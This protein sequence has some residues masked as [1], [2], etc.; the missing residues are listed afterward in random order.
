MLLAV[1]SALPLT[2]IAKDVNMKGLYVAGKGK[3]DNSQVAGQVT[4]QGKKY[5]YYRVAGLD[6]PCYYIPDMPGVY[7]TAKDR[8]GY[9][10]LEKVLVET[11]K[12]FKGTLTLLVEGSIC[13]EL[14]NSKSCIRHYYG[15]LVIDRPDNTPRPKLE[16]IQEGDKT[17]MF[18]SHGSAV[19]NNIT[20]HILTMA[21]PGVHNYTRPRVTPTDAIYIESGGRLNFNNVN[22]MTRGRIRASHGFG[23]KDCKFQI[24]KMHWSVANLG[25]LCVD[26]EKSDYVVIKATEGETA[27]TTTTPTQPTT[28]TKPTEPTNTTSSVGV[29]RTSTTTTSRSNT[30][31]STTSRRTKRS[32]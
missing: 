8:G 31:N 26:G 11:T 19:I 25:Y 15:N 21:R 27:S 16:L 12:N 6:D 10:K 5:N 7:V 2:A 22:L 30:N 4:Y 17:G 1:L 20:L 29:S 9:V 3:Y 18:L 24:S 28:T 32:K 14:K 13:V 23:L